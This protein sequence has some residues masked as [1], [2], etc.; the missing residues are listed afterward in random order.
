M[1]L[2]ID[3]VL[4]ESDLARDFIA[5][6]ERRDLPEKFFYW[7][8]LSVRAWLAL[9]GGDGAYRNFN[10]SYQL[11]ARHAPAV[12][13][14]TL[15]GAVEVV[16]L[17]AGQGDKDRL[18]LAALRAAG[19]EVSYRP[20]D[21]SIG[22]LEIAVRDAIADGVATIGVKADFTDV[23][24]LRSFAHAPAGQR[25]TRLFLMLGNTLG[26]FDPAQL[27]SQLASLMHPGDLAVIDGELFAGSETLA[28]YDNPI[29]R[30]FAFGP[31]EGAGLSPED[32]ELVFDTQ[33]DAVRPG[34]YRVT[35]QFTARREARLSVAGEA[36]TLRA[37]DR[38][39]MSPSHKYDESAFLAILDDA[40]LTR[41]ATYTADDGRFIMTLVQRAAPE[42]AQLS[43]RAAV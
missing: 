40:P 32:G 8:P 16:S 42:H 21:A 41:V 7:F 18:I 6:L 31:L 5:A 29:N 38:L 39:A 1:H 13:A 14:R 2:P 17:G 36:L 19:R 34:L 43:S 27:A 30:R 11:V 20:V 25:V 4:T 9:C 24:Q 26:A 12:A 15:P 3:V 33:R 10:R 28:G 23:A 22:L 35:K 37:Q